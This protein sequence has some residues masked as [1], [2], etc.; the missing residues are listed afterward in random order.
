M[1]TSSADH[2]AVTRRVN[3]L[4][5]DGGEVR[6]VVVRRTLD[7]SVDQTWS[8]LTETDRVPRWFLPLTGDLRVGGRFQLEGHAGG[9]VLACVRPEM[10]ALTWEHA[11]ETS[12][13]DISLRPTPAGT[14]LQLDHTAPLTPQRWAEF[15]PGAVGIG[16][17]MVLLGLAEHVADPDRE[18]VAPADIADLT[19]A[20][21]AAWTEAAIADGDDAED[22]R[23][24]GE[25]CVAAYLG[26]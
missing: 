19:R 3:T 6:V 4:A 1:N 17:E 10:V 20:A 21:G 15:G 5:P 9:E 16:W 2:L 22:A 12:R 14:L 18:V 25:R 7:A 23:A 8:A 26:E 11:G 13:I 24:A